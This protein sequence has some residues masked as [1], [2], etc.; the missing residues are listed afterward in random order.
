MIP[1]MMNKWQQARFDIHRAL[2]CKFFHRKHHRAVPTAMVKA[3]YGWTW[4]CHKC[5]YIDVIYL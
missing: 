3:Y 1:P 4:Y 2:I 5:C